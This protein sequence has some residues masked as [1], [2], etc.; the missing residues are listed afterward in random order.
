M[1]IISIPRLQNYSG[2]CRTDIQPTP[3][4]SSG[5]R[6]DVDRSSFALYQA[7]GFGWD[8]LFIGKL[9]TGNY[10]CKELFYHIYHT[11]YFTCQSLTHW[12][13]E[14]RFAATVIPSL[15]QEIVWHH[16]APN[17]FLYQCWSFIRTN[18]K[19]TFDLNI[20]H[21]LYVLYNLI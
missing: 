15:L 16:L 5:Y 4:A 10:F 12:S 3:E 1:Y 9:F 21:S 17:H 2:R 19:Q 18:L 8:L 13:R 14:R 20:F 11:M 7:H 6:S